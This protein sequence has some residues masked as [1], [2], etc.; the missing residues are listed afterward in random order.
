MATIRFVFLSKN[1]NEYLRPFMR[2]M[3]SP[4]ALGIG[5]VMLCGVLAAGE[6]RAQKPG[7]VRAREYAQSLDER[8][9]K[10]Y[11]NNR[12]FLADL[13]AVIRTEDPYRKT[14]GFFES[15]S[16]DSAQAGTS[17][18]SVRERLKTLTDN[19][20]TIKDKNQFSA[21]IPDEAALNSLHADYEKTF[22]TDYEMTKMDAIAAR[23]KLIGSGNETMRRV[24]G[25]QLKTAMERFTGK[26]YLTAA[27]ELTDIYET[28]KTHFT[29]WDDV[30]YYLGL[31]YF[32]A[33]DFDNAETYFYKTVTDFPSS[34]FV[35]K[36]LLKLLVISYVE[37]D[38]T[39]MQ[40]YFAEFEAKVAP[41]PKDDLEYNQVFFLTGITSFKTSDFTSAIATLN[42]IPKTS[43]YYYPA[44][45][46]IG[47]CYANQDAYNEALESFQAVIHLTPNNKKFD[48]ELQRKLKDLAQ[49]KSAWVKFEQTT[50]GQKFKTVYPFL[51]Q[52]PEAAEVHDAALLASAWSLFK[53]NIIDS[54]R[55]FVDSMVR[56]NPSSDLLFEAKTL[57]GNIQVLDP[58]LSDKDRELQAVD[59]YNYVAGATEA[60]YLSDLFIA[61]RDSSLR[62]LELLN[63]A[64]EVSRVKK[65][66]AEYRKYDNL[67]RRVENSIYNSGFT[68]S[69]S[70]GTRSPGYYQTMSNLI[71]RIRI[72]SGQLKNAQEVK[73]Q[74]QV[75]QINKKLADLLNQFQAVGGEKY[76]EN[77]YGTS[78]STGSLSD[79]LAS[80]ETQNYFSLNKVPRLISEI[81]SRNRMISV[82]KEKISREKE[83]IQQQLTN[84]DQ[85]MAT[86]K[87]RNKPSIMIRL[88]FEKN[89][90]MD[91]YYQLTDY[92][93]MLFPKDPVESYVDLDT[94]GDFASYGRNNITY[95]INTT[96]TETIKDV[97]RAVAQI[98]KILLSRKKSY[99][100]RIASIEEEI[101]VKEQ[102]IKDK[103]MQESRVS[104]QQF[105]Q[106]E[107][108]KFKATEKPENDPYD[109]KDLVPEVV[110]ITD[111]M[112]MTKKAVDST[113][114]K[115][116][117]D[118]TAKMKADTTG[119][120]GSTETMKADTTGKTGS[121]EKAKSDTSGKKE[122]DSVK[123]S[124]KTEPKK[125]SDSGTM[126]NDGDTKKNKSD[127]EPDSTKKDG[128][129]RGEIRPGQ[130]KTGNHACL[131]LAQSGIQKHLIQREQYFL[132][133]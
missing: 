111:S 19:L 72:T 34:T 27:L 75:D 36:G 54:A 101:K 48:V 59:A 133:S 126:K 103:E 130:E 96:K 81:E 39:K 82:L 71:S 104:Q 50:N 77:T 18:E 87:E 1:F 2:M 30:L 108:F 74:K 115:A 64:R 45:Y 113:E 89:K 90:L 26:K 114:A 35:R 92:E 124:E 3:N 56:T 21:T 127:S 53:D 120:T 33:G 73:D 52:I 102:E 57:I 123:K 49:L 42:K 69:S 32:R 76:V 5:L 128:G 38:R 67:Y 40:K 125:D 86:A 97:A 129:L 51:K 17:R 132:K 55:M 85:L 106:K 7:K 95:V 58:Q 94:W 63:R 25:Q 100:S 6:A 41:N 14:K 118:S 117:V 47:H 107:Y 116:A 78:D 122:S 44:L 9:D 43:R 62:V 83:L 10:R 84:V 93:I 15:A 46:L 24:F 99:E 66:T 88:E 28:Y 31:S 98:D 79:E 20:K 110:V 70:K 13:I 11:A 65:D 4:A 109:Y 8:F 119:K 121:T 23:S 80:V 131:P 22:A 68:R 16:G 91:L 37:N 105:F 60:K 29:E 112:G 12:Q 61:E